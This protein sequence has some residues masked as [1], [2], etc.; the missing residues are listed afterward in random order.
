MRERVLTL[1]TTASI[2][3]SEVCDVMFPFCCFFH[4][5]S[6][7]CCCHFCERCSILTTVELHIR[8]F[9]IIILFGAVLVH[10]TNNTNCE[11]VEDRSVKER[12]KLYF[13]LVGCR[14]TRE[15]DLQLTH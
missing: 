11:W 8:T 7:G 9:V 4:S 6:I 12:Q 1:N 5:K 15:K 14:P 13:R 2:K 10:R 3:V